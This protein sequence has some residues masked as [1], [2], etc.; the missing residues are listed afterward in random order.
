M[1]LVLSWHMKAATMCEYSKQ[2]FIGGLQALG[3]VSFLLYVAAFVVHIGYHLKLTKDS[4]GVFLG[5][6]DSLEKFCE[7]ILYMSSELK[8]ERKSEV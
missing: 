2:E 7:R 1:Q 8:D 5:R 6:I 4:E 3:Y